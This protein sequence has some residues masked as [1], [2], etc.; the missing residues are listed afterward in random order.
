MTGFNFGGLQDDKTRLE[1]SKTVIVPVP[2]DGTTSFRSGT[3]EGP[4]AIIS[5]SRFL[6]LYD[7]ET[8][9]DV[10]EAG[11]AT[12]GELE[13]LAS[14]PEAMIEAVRE[15]CLPLLQ[16]GKTVVVLGGEHSVSLGAI[17]AAFD[18]KPSFSILQFD[19]HADL[20]NSYQNTP[21][22]HACV[23]RRAMEYNPIE[24]V[25]IRSL[26]REE[27]VF[28]KESGLKP[29]YAPA[30]LADR[31]AVLQELLTRLLPEVYITIDLD[32]LDPS[33]MPAVG[34]PE[35]GGL[36]WYD[37]LFFLRHIARERHVLAFDVVELL[38]QPGNVAP[39]FLAAKLIYKLLN[40]IG[41]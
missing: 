2:Y 21:V 14:S 28:I 39:D 8:D 35:P 27:A 1:S 13:P 15:A 33:I 40:Y 12:L 17:K 23:M 34:T 30:V 4:L 31:E 37:L 7:E 9:Q 20:R 36:G 22:S 5:A 10:S 32:V 11:I 38:P 25:G 3:R 24:Q 26:S 41:H 29:F 19:A 16:Q 6:E 18:Y